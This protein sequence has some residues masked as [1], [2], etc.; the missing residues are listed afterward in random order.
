MQT[1]LIGYV[2]AALVLATFWMKVPVRLRQVG[3]AS[4]VAFIV[5]GIAGHLVPIAVLH[6]ILLPINLF[7]LAEL[8]KIARRI[9][10]ALETDLSMDWLRPMM[11]S[12]SLQTGDF[13]F[14]K[15][16][17]Q[18]DIRDGASF[19][20]VLPHTEASAADTIA[21][22]VR[23]AVGALAFRPRFTVGVATALPD[24]SIDPLTLVERASGSAR[25]AEAD[26]AHSGVDHLR[27]ASS[28]AEA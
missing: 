26:M 21:R 16:D 1:Q 23:Q 10:H 25:A 28:G 7:R 4:N 27:H 18:T 15:G 11:R 5:Y 3:I 19:V 8:K 6:A 20:A 17:E 2:A 24:R 14:R 22:E 9:Q 12:R 13:L